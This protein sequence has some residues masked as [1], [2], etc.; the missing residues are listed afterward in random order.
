M[1]I[2]KKLSSFICTPAETPPDVARI[3]DLC[4][5][6]WASVL[7]AGRAEPVARLV[8][9]QAKQDE[10]K[11]ESQVIGLDRRLPARA[12]SLVNGIT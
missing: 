7:H 6:D 2:T 1:S 9:E 11:E 5:L 4:L 12:A 10:G 3:V 8:R